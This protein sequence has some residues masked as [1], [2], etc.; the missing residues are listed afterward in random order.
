MENIELTRSLLEEE[1]WDLIIM[2]G[3]RVLI[4]SIE[5]GITPFFQTVQSLGWSLH[6]AVM[7]DRII[8]LA[9]A[10]ICLH[11]GITSVCW[12]NKPGNA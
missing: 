12:H 6:N 9:V 7:A 4:S 1:K 2:K 8:G 10:M 11:A 5:R 3:R